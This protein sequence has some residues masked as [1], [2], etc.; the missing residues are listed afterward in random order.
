[1]ASRDIL[2]FEKASARWD[3][4]HR[5]EAYSVPDAMGVIAIVCS[6]SFEHAEKNDAKGLVNETRI[7]ASDLQ[8][9]GRKVLAVKNGTGSDI[10]S[11]LKDPTI[12]SMILIGH[13]N[14]SSFFVAD[15]MRPNGKKPPVAKMSM[16]WW[17][18]ARAADHLK[19]GV[20][21]QRHCG[22]LSN[23][24]SVPLG[25]FA[26]SYHGN[27][28]APVGYEFDPTTDTDFDGEPQ[29]RPFADTRKLSL[30]Y[31]LDRTESAEEDTD[32]EPQDFIDSQ[33]L[34]APRLRARAIEIGWAALQRF[35]Y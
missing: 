2:R 11:M 5:D 23:I 22:T 17:D 34:P 19:T 3:Q 25:T 33:P 13:G 28:L 14:L 27:V 31:V 29:L 35:P 8:A 20:F 26:M 6:Q 21:I 32:D 1:M 18:I 9:Q 24:L 7:V 30:D 10:R 16:N 4:L 15:G 12:S